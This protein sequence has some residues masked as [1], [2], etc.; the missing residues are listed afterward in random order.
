MNKIIVLESQTLPLRVSLRDQSDS[1]FL[2]TLQGTCRGY[3]KQ[4][5]PMYVSNR[6]V[7]DKESTTHHG[8]LFPSSDAQL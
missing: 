6:E 8:L 7:D 4:A 1:C 3:T 5:L 2:Y